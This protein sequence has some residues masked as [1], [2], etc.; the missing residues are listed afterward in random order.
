[1][2]RHRCQKSQVVKNILPLNVLNRLVPR[3]AEQG[4]QGLSPELAAHALTRRGLAA[5]AASASH[6]GLGEAPQ[7]RSGAETASESERADG[8]STNTTSVARRLPR[9]CEPQP[10]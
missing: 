4:A 3:S 9:A 10:A 1:M 2:G 6:P 8:V 7:R 5:V